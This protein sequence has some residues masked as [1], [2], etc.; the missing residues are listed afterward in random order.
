[1]QRRAVY[2]E[3]NL[4]A[5]NLNQLFVDVS[6]RKLSGYFKVSYWDEDHYILY[7]EGEAITGMSIERDGSRKNIDYKGYKPKEMSGTVSFFEVP[8]IN[9]L[10][11]RDQQRTPPTPYNFV[12]Y[13]REFLSC[14]RLSHIDLEKLMHHMKESHLNGYMVLS[15]NREFLFMVMLQKGTPVALYSDKGYSTD[16]HK[17][18]TVDRESSYIAAYATEPEVPLIFASMENMEKIIETTFMSREEFL[19]VQ[20]EVSTKK[21]NAFFDVLLYGGKRLYEF[22]Y[23]GSLIFKT[24][25][26]LDELMDEHTDIL[27]GTKNRS[28][29]YSLRIKE[30]LNPMDIS[31]EVAS[32]IAPPLRANAAFEFIEESKL[33]AVRAYFI[34]EIGPIGPLLWNKILKERGYEERHMT[35]NNLMELIDILY[36]E[37]P[38]EKHAKR[39]LEKARRVIE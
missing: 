20:K 17:S 32:R 22:F 13:G 29:L 33:V 39:F 21:M 8:L 28:S 23:R 10:L 25:H 15:S 35:K 36:R 34:E 14:M 9:V 31:I 12:S 5:V 37:I 18:F 4:G 3:L 16:G 38:D 7:T 6:S 19:L 30:F 24:V 2:S 26:A 27:P 11:F 1:M